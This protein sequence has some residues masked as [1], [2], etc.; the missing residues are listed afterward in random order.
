VFN[1]SGNIILTDADLKIIAIS[2][3]VS[4]ADGQEPQRVGLQY[5]LDNRQNYQGIP[6]LTKARVQEALQAGVTK[7]ASGA[8]T[9]KKIK[10]KAGTDLRRT[11]A[12]SITELPPVLVENTLQDAGFD[13]TVALDKILED[14]ELLDKLVELLV[15]ARSIVEGITSTD[16]CTG[17]IF[18]KRREKVTGTVP[19]STAEDQGESLLYED[20]HPFIPRKFKNDETFKVLDFQGYNKT[21]DE[22]FSSLEG[23]KLESR[24]S[25]RQAA[26]QRKLDAAKQDQAKRLEGLQETQTLN[27]RKAAAIEANAEWVQEAMDAVNGL[28]MQGMDWVDIERLIEREQK[29]NNPVAQMIKTPLKLAE[30]IVTLILAEEDENEDQED[31]AYETDEEEK[32]DSDDEAAVG[33]T[34]SKQANKGLSIEINLS[35]SPWSNAREYY[36]QRREAVVKEEKTQQQAARAL[37]NTE[38]KITEDLKK[39]LKQ[40]KAL[41]QPIRKQSWYEKFTWFISSDNYL[42]LGGKDAQQNEMLYRRYLRKGDIYCHAELHGAASVIIKNNP[43]T[44]DAPIP[45]ATLAQ[46][47]SLSVCSSS[48]WDSKAGMSAWWVNADQVSKSAPTGEFLPTGSFMIRG[49]KN[50]LPPAQLLL[51]LGLVFRISDD[52]KAKHVKHRLYDVPSTGT[53]TPVS[54][55]TRDS[56][57]D[58]DQG[59]ENLSDNDDNGED[60]DSDNDENETSARANPLQTA[61]GGADDGSDNE[62]SGADVREKMSQLE[63]DE[64]K[65]NAQ[66]DK[67]EVDAADNE[68]ED[69]EASEDETESPAAQDDSKSQA[70][71]A[72]TKGPMPAKRGQKKKAKKIAR[73]YK[74]QDDE[75]RAAAEA[76]IGAKTGQKRAEDEAKAKVEKEAELAAAKERRRAQHQ[77]HQKET[78]EHEEIRRVM[79]DEGVETLDAEEAEQAT[80][81]DSLVGTPLPG[82]EILEIIPVCAPWSALVKTKYKVKLQP[83]AMKKGKAVKEILERWKAATSKKGVVDEAGRDAERM[84]PREVELIKGL[85]AEEIINSVPVGKVRVMTAG[86]TAGGGGA[87]GK[88]GGKGVGKGGKGGKGG[89]R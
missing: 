35:L 42:V 75:D 51:G 69:D 7:A 85:K 50:F 83:G 38:Q 8:T 10:Q 34:T 61:A 28:L 56:A 58:M 22:F 66:A 73:K 74:D 12:I 14:D 64:F 4:E 40:E 72:S 2:R 80:A 88:G 37:K 63:V 76:I 46:A 1:Q 44:P 43:S 79:M 49:K 53:S 11:L 54:A 18:A 70:T 81:L 13:T 77:R 89:K 48:A 36:G 31:E 59:Q 15:K 9:S 19:D 32:D 68:D 23:Q 26:A 62:D 47:G 55:D 5:S 20:F 16:I 67:N 17:Y 87:G 57:V 24:L 33:Q 71:S 41:L 3:I 27:L 21:V 78:A 52:S 6:P 86:G 45:P 84:W 29:R 30:N 82:D 25:E 39:G 65:T 60:G